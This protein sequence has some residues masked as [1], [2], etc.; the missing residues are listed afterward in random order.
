MTDPRDD[1]AGCPWCGALAARVMLTNPE[2][3]CGEILRLEDYGDEG[4]EADAHAFC[5]MCGAQ[6]APVGVHLFDASDYDEALAMAASSW[7]NRQGAAD[8]DAAIRADARRYRRLLHQGLR[9]MAN[10]VLHK[11]KAE[12]DAAIDALPDPP[13]GSASRM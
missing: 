3:E 10:G 4:V 7:N 5:H 6:C 8:A 1:L 9:F 2:P 13:P 11:T 12:T